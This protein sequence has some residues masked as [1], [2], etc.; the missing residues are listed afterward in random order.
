MTFIVFVTIK[1]LKAP[2]KCYALLTSIRM[3]KEFTKG[4]LINEGEPSADLMY[5][6]SMLLAAV[7]AQKYNV[8]NH[9]Q[10]AIIKALYNNKNTGSYG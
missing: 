8:L 1:V 3:P 6:P 10:D 9:Q 4:A 2:D 7:S 5:T